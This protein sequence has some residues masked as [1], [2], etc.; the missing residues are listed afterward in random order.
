[1]LG[2]SPTRASG[3]SPRTPRVIP[4][5]PVQIRSHTRR[6]RLSPAAP[7]NVTQIEQ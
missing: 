6:V 2:H 7:K 3:H 4:V 1:M 5:T